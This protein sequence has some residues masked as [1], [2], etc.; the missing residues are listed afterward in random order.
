MAPPADGL[1]VVVVDVDLA[2]DVVDGRRAGGGG[3]GGQAL[4][5]GDAREGLL[6]ATPLLA[7]RQR[8]REV[9]QGQRALGDEGA[10]GGG[11]T[12]AATRVLQQAGRGRRDEGGGARGEGEGEEGG[13]EGPGPACGRRCRRS[14]ACP[15]AG[16]KGEVR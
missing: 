5:G 13:G 9:N 15:S 7:G 1:L 14:D 4:L 12:Q 16:W 10:G 11:R 6:D 3:G 2:P 8:A